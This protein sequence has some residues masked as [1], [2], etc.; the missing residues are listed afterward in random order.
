MVFVKELNQ[1]NQTE[2]KKK[3]I[4]KEYVTLL[5]IKPPENLPEDYDKVEFI[6][7]DSHYGDVFKAWD[8]DLVGFSLYFGEKGDENYE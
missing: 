3:T 4:F 1:E 5:G 2:V 6:G 7:H 8:D